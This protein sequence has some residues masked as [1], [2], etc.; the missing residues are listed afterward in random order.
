M[1]EVRHHFNGDQAIQRWL[2]Q[3][4]RALLVRFTQENGEPQR[5]HS[6]SNYQLSP[7]IQAMAPR[8]RKPIYEDDKEQLVTILEEKYR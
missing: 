6:W 8:E 2:E 3:Q 1:D 5:T 7:E 4:V